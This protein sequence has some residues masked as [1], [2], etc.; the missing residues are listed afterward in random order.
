MKQFWHESATEE[1]W[2]L[3]Q[4]IAKSH[5]FVLIGGWAAYLHTHTQKSKDIDIVVDFEELRLLDAEFSLVKNERLRK[6][7]IKQGEV[8]IDVYVPK[9]SRLSY[10]PEKLLGKHTVVEGIPVASVEQLLLLKLG[11]YGD[12]KGSVKGEKDAIDIVSLLVAAKFDKR[13]FESEAADSGVAE[14][15]GTLKRI[16]SEFPGSALGFVGVEYVEFKKWRK[17]FLKQRTS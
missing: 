10:A 3:L 11:A 9:F 7:E 4:R 2:K 1:S 16:V 6:Y 12:R 17:E 13:R 15:L 5:K 8:D 14:P